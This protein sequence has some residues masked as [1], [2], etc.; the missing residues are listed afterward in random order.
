MVWAGDLCGRRHGCRA[1]VAAAKAGTHAGPCMYLCPR[2]RMREEAVL[3]VRAGQ[4]ARPGARAR[5]AAAA[6]LGCLLQ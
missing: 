3:I 1:A 5:R 4:G 2:S 6:T